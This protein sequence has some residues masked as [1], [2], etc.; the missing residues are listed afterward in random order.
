MQNHKTPASDAAVPPVAEG[1]VDALWQRV[2]GRRSFSGASALQAR[3]RRRRRGS[4]ASVKTFREL[5]GTSRS[6]PEQD[7]SD[8]RQ[9]QLR[10][11]S[12]R[13]RT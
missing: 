9:R 11:P 7:E 10:A 5:I 3:P 4:A 6:E 1:G 13:R 8:D 12:P 2:V